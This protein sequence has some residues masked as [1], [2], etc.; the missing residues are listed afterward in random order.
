MW[1]TFYNVNDA[2]VNFSKK[3][4]S[5]YSQY[6]G[7]SQLIWLILKL[8]LKISVTIYDNYGRIKW[9]IKSICTNCLKYKSILD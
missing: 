4:V 7:N 3:K 8:C 6:F 1:Y 2:T 5:F 9:W